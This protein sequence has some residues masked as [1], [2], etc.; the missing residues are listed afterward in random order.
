ME[1]GSHVI[2]FVAQVKG[3]LVVRVLHKSMSP[4]LRRF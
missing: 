3:I 1:E 4:Q 2:F